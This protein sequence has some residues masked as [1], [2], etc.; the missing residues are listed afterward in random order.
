MKKILLPLLAASALP[1]SALDID[2]V[3][4]EGITLGMD[5]QQAIKIAQEK[6]EKAGEKFTVFQNKF[7][8]KIPIDVSICEGPKGDFG[9]ITQNNK[10]LIILNYQRISIKD[11]EEKV[12]EE[13]RQLIRKKAIDKYGEPNIQFVESEN[14]SNISS[15]LMIVGD[16]VEHSFKDLLC[17]GCEKQRYDPEKGIYIDDTM[18]HIFEIN[19]KG[20][21]VTIKKGKDEITVGSILADVESIY[22][23]LHADE[24][25]AQEAAAKAQQEKEAQENADAEKAVENIK[26]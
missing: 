21:A 7:G 2:K 6:C 12:I 10:T 19:Q 4:I 15:E 18:E 20:F 1:A 11:K 16:R 17:W 14:S 22:R 9:V 26:F 5:S 23:T 3:E 8:K 24:I 13:M 25:K